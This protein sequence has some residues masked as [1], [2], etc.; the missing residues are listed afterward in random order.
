VGLG[1]SVGVGLGVEVGVAVAVG[2]GVCVGL[3]VAVQ[4]GVDVG[5]A[6]QAAARVSD[7]P[8]TISLPGSDVQRCGILSPQGLPSGLCGYQCTSDYLLLQ[9]RLW[10]WGLG[11]GFDKPLGACYTAA[12]GPLAQPGRAGAF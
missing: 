11:P 8:A 10:A 7:R 9:D 2:V 12:G 4:V 6:E 1:V 5:G 3:G